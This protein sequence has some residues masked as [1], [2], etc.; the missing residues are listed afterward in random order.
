[1][2]VACRNSYAH[3]AEPLLFD[4]PLQSVLYMTDGSG[5]WGAGVE[6]AAWFR[7]WLAETHDDDN[8]VT[9]TSINAALRRGIE[10]LPARIAGCDDGWSLS[11]VAAIVENHE[12]QLGVSGGF[13]AVAVSPSHI[14]RLFTPRRL[15]D[16]LVAQ[17][18]V[19]ELEA[20]THRYARVLCGP[21]F[22]DSENGDLTWLAPITIGSESRIMIGESGLQ[23][24]LEANQAQKRQ[25]DPVELR[26]VVEEFSGHSSPTAIITPYRFSG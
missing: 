20:A 18:V 8:L 26:D 3:G 22:G 16:E 17:G 15:V 24:Y 25:C 10:C 1:M 14:H 4:T 12:I 5:S 9:S 7:E 11:I 19:T 2:I 6:A 13:A 21:F 23:R